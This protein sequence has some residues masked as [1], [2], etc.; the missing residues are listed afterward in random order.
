MAV[1]IVSEAPVRTQRVVC[2]NCC[3]EL[4]FTGVDVK[5]DWHE[6]TGSRSWIICPN[7]ECKDSVVP[8]RLTHISVKWLRD[9]G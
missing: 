2:P 3:Y 7:K 5:Y 1:K 9:G 6:D 4:E 8:G